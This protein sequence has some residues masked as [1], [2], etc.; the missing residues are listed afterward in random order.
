M[1][2]IVKLFFKLLPSVGNNNNQSEYYLPDVLSLIIN[3]G[4]NVAIEK[5]DNIDEIQGVNNIQQLKVLNE[6]FNV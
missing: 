1:F 3:N 4:D 6:K 2:L 5:T